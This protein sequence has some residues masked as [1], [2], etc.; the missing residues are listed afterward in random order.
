[1]LVRVT[2]PLGKR[3]AATAATWG[4]ASLGSAFGAAYDKGLALIRIRR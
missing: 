3:L 4:A 1:V 2:R